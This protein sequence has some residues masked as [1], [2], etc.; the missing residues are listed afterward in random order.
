MQNPKEQLLLIL[1]NFDFWSDKLFGFHQMLAFFK[2][3]MLLQG[4]LLG[5]DA[6]SVG[7]NFCTEFLTVNGRQR[8]K[9]KLGLQNAKSFA[10]WMD[11]A[12][13]Y[14][15]LNG[16][17]K[18]RQD[19]SSE[20][21]DE[22]KLRERI[23]NISRM[24]HNNDI[25]SLIYRL[26]GGLG[27]AKFS[28]QHEGMY[29]RALSGTK[30]ITTKYIDTVCEALDSIADTP[31]HGKIPLAVR[32]AFF[33]ETRRAFGRTALLLSGGAYLGYYHMGLATALYK[34]GM[35]PKVMS[36]AS[37]GSL[38]VANLGTRSEEELE[39]LFA[40]PADVS[41]SDHFAYGWQA[42]PIESPV[43]DTIR[44]CLPASIDY[45][46]DMAYCLLFWPKGLLLD[47]DHLKSVI[48]HNCGVYTFQEAFDKTGRIINI[49][50][51][52]QNSYDPPRLLNYLTAPHVCVWSAALASCAIPGAFEPVPLIVRE[53]N[54]EYRAENRWT[55]S[56]Q[57]LKRSFSF[58]AFG[59]S[60]LKENR[61]GDISGL[62]RASGNKDEVVLY[63]DGS[64][65]SDLPMQQLSEQFNVNHFI[66]SQVNPHSCLFSASSVTA[67]VWAPAVFGYCVG[68]V[69]FMKTLLKDWIKSLVGLMM[70]RNRGPVW[71]AR[72]GV[73]QL[74]TQE[75]EGRDEDITIMPWKDHIS[76]FGAFRD[77]IKNPTDAEYYE[78]ARAAERA[79]WP[80]FARISAHCA[81]ETTLDECVARLR[82][83]VES[84]LE[85]D[86]PLPPGEMPEPLLSKQQQW[87]RSDSW[88]TSRAQLDS[89]SNP[90]TSANWERKQGATQQVL[91][92]FRRSDSMARRDFLPRS[93][94]GNTSGVDDDLLNLAVSADNI[95]LNSQSP[96][97]EGHD[98]GQAHGAVTNTGGRG[99]GRYS[100]PGNPNWDDIVMVDEESRMQTESNLTDSNLRSGSIDST[101]DL[102]L[103]MSRSGSMASVT[104]TAS[105]S[106]RR[107]RAGSFQFEADEDSGDGNTGALP[108]IKR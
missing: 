66:V 51:S 94:S 31:Q 55:K 2:T 87:R 23:E 84:E 16:G 93:S 22:K 43:L 85:H 69:R 47:I 73:F 8:R 58:N 65:E 1:F 27:R 78:V 63:T 33:R 96:M 21:Y 26:R 36:G 88:A 89:F 72:R 91:D 60:E 54:G 103:P 18:W 106:S 107:M 45:L 61:I 9:L 32:L 19:D 68:Y 100:K 6:L 71:A 24:T 76:I 17:L 70:C 37:A 92:E 42:K 56:A 3:A 75:Y 44:S 104:S 13:Q 35:L 11:Y 102:G 99:S 59:A 74:L 97:S 83:A 50:V 5:W 4:L 86:D 82:L 48:I 105:G 34:H 52:P 38:M 30:H 67:S 98:D 46:A 14:D 10:E 81:V 7:F 101:G 49:T 28:M 53:P 95:P 39:R 80:Y 15:R 40:N 20:F 108:S 90:D 77:M 25:F 57:P 64:V 79:T 41:R 29:T 12:T 62:A